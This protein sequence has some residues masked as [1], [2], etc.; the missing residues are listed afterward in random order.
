MVSG[1]DDCAI[2]W[3]VV[4]QGSALVKKEWQEVFAASGASACAHLGIGWALVVVYFKGVIPVH[5]E[6]IN[7]FRIQRIFPRREQVDI[8]RLALRFFGSPDQ[9]S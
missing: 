8:G 7:S 4:K 6:S 2:G 1:G 9:M 3:Q 5:L